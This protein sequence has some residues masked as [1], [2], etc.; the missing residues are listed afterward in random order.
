[1]FASVSVVSPVS[2]FSVV[3]PATMTSA[4]WLIVPAVTLKASV[5]VTEAVGENVTMSLASPTIVRSV[6]ALR[7]RS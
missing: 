4:D 6:F 1:L 3:T 2:E 7:A 5:I